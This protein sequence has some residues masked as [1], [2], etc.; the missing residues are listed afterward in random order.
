[1]GPW[2]TRCAVLVL[3]MQQEKVK[4]KIDAARQILTHLEVL[5]TAS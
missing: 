4:Q 3:P 5:D 2:D 1:M